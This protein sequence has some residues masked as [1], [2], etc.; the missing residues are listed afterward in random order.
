L[1]NKLE[2]CLLE[3]DKHLEL[4]E[5]CRDRAKAYPSGVIYGG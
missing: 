2:R 1:S 3:A 5:P 4:V